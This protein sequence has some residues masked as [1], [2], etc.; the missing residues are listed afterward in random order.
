MLLKSQTIWGSVSVRTIRHTINIIL[1]K[2]T[3]LLLFLYDTVWDLLIWS[4][5]VRARAAVY[6]T[7]HKVREHVVAGCVTGPGDVFGNLDTTVRGQEVLSSLGCLPL[8][9]GDRTGGC[10]RRMLQCGSS[11]SDSGDEDVKSG[12][13]CGV[14]QYDRQCPSVAMGSKLPVLMTV[15]ALCVGARRCQPGQAL[16][17]SQSDA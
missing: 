14:R 2:C 10:R 9:Q 12:R 15:I 8:C 7:Y 6:R 16:S 17:F 13:K 3:G 5:I 4:I 1:K 11:A